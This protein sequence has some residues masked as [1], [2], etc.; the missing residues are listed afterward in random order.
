MQEIY[1]NSSQEEAKNYVVI[2][3]DKSQECLELQSEP[4]GSSTS[5]F[6]IQAMEETQDDWQ[7]VSQSKVWCWLQEK[8]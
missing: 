3:E 7:Q 5:K 1:E 2:D 6:R 4:S 8:V